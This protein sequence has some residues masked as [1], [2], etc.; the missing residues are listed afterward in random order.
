MPPAHRLDAGGPAA[1]GVREMAYNLSQDEEVDWTA[2][3]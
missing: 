1:P 3:G 2:S